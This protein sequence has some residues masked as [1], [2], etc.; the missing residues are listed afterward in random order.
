ML[1]Y[2]QGENSNTLVT[3]S[4][5]TTINNPFYLFVF[6]HSTTKSK[7]KV[8]V[9]SSSDL[10]NY[11]DRYNKFNLSTST[12]FANKPCGFW[13]YEVFESASNTTNETGLRSI[14]F[15]KMKLLDPKI[16]NKGYEP[17]AQIKGYEG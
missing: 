5:S 2:N 17:T 11:K 9:N 3:L 1:Y 6:K 15:G 16:V 7:V 8:C 4:E 10:S 12:L 14:E 13:S